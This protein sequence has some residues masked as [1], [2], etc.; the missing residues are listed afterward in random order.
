MGKT[1]WTCVQNTR[2]RRPNGE[3]EVTS[4]KAELKGEWAGWRHDTVAG[5]K[6]NVSSARIKKTFEGGEGGKGFTA[7]SPDETRDGGG[8]SCRGDRMSVDRSSGR[9]RW[10]GTSQAVSSRDE[11]CP[12]HLQPPLIRGHNQEDPRDQY[13]RK[14]DK[15]CTPQRGWGRSGGETLSRETPP[16]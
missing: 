15:K 10:K 5:G 3:N 1:R 16:T 11:E 6:K 9:K 4:A 8:G 2:S 14:G 13:W 7:G 12:L